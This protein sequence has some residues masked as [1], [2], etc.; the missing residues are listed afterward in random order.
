MSNLFDFSTKLNVTDI[1]SLTSPLEH[2]TAVELD[3]PMA[4]KEKST[5]ITD[6]EFRR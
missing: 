5:W 6:R 3:F 1:G 4:G 2:I